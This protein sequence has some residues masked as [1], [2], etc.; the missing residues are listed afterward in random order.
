MKKGL[1]L[2]KTLTALSAD[3]VCNNLK[4]DQ[5]IKHPLTIY[6]LRL[7]FKALWLL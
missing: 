5:E 1:P 7:K 2:E 6:V 3:L 4:Y